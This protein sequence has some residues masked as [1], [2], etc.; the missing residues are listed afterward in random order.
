MDHDLPPSRGTCDRTRQMI[1]AQRVKIFLN[2]FP[3][4]LQYRGS[5]LSY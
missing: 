1:R 5:K 4:P 3:A 2:P